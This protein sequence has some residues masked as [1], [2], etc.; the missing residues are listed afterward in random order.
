MT[1]LRARQRA[2]GWPFSTHA[3]ASADFTHSPATCL[4]ATF[5]RFHTLIER[6]LNCA[7]ASFGCAV[8]YGFGFADL[9][10]LA[11]RHGGR[12]GAEHDGD[13]VAS[14][15]KTSASVS[16]SNE[17]GCPKERKSSKKTERGQAKP[18]LPDHVLPAKNN[19]FRRSNKVIAKLDNGNDDKCRHGWSEQEIHKSS[20]PRELG[21]K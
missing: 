16:T 11:R 19:L 8:G 4:V 6:G 14:R 2:T 1:A 5:R 10:W 17:R 7:G 13:S 18:D 9:C 12:V 21:S 15:L 3:R 20:F